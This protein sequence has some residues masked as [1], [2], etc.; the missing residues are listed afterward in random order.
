MNSSTRRAICRRSGFGNRPFRGGEKAQ[1]AG[2]RIVEH[3]NT[4]VLTSINGNEADAFRIWGWKSSVARYER[5]YVNG[6]GDR[7]AYA[8]RNDWYSSGS[9]SRPVKRVASSQ[10]VTSCVSF[11]KASGKE[12]STMGRGGT[13]EARRRWIL[14]LK[15]PRTVLPSCCVEFIAGRRE[16]IGGQ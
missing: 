3:G 4:T 16:E 6:A 2:S 13:V 1:F 10:S 8:Q 15:E 5:E 11:W 9:G 14:V 7:E 12:S